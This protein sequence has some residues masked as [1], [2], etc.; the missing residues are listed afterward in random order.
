MGNGST[1]RVTDV[2]SRPKLGTCR[3]AAPRMFYA[4]AE[5]TIISARER[6]ETTGEFAETH[7]KIPLNSRTSRK[8]PE[9]YTF[10]ICGSASEL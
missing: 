10:A 1:S 7:A 3:E 5:D 9:T 4:A 6:T 2:W 8:Y